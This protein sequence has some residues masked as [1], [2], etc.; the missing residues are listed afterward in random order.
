MIRLSSSFVRTL[1][2]DPADAEVASHKLLVRAGYI[3][4]SAPGVY[5]WL[6]LG[7]KVLRKVEAI[8]RE[9][10]DAIGGQELV[11]SALQPREPYEATGR[12]EEYGPTLFR[13]QDR[14]R[15]RLPARAHPRGDVHPHREGPV[16]LVQGPPRHALPGAEQVPRRGTPPRWPA[17]HA[18]VRHEGRLLLRHRRRGTGR[19]LREAARCL[20][21]HL[22][23][24]GPAHR[25]LPGRCRRHGR[26]PLR[27]VPAPHTHRRGHLR[28]LRRRLRRERRG[29][30]HRRPARPGRGRDRGAAPDAR[31]GHAGS[32]HHRGAHGVLQPGLPR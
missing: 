32:E 14:Q 19:L 17:A 28:G 23:T 13:L 16:Q 24:P 30:D 11:F 6:P 1:R 15:G 3:R 9:E 10:Q 2:E 25:D 5:T 4:R 20:P 21:A 22:R 31:R 18:R 8:V 12:W 7:L 27:G 26:F 29:G